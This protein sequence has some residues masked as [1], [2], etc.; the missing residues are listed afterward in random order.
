MKRYRIL[1]HRPQGKYKACA[2]VG[3]FTIESVVQHGQV[4][5]PTCNQLVEVIEDG[6]I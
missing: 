5:C 2:T 4:L 3:S 1:Y 6:V